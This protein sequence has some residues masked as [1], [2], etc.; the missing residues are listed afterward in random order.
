MSAKRHRVTREV[1]AC[2]RILRVQ[3]NATTLE[4]E[5][6]WNESLYAAIDKATWLAASEG[7][8]DWRLVED[9]RVLVTGDEHGPR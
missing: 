8:H 4:L 5:G 7:W 6:F 3:I 2:R 1:T 9:G